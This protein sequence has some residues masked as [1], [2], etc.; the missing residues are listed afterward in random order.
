MK[1][2]LLL[3]VLLLLPP[4][5]AAGR[6]RPQQVARGVAAL[7]PPPRL[8]PVMGWNAWNTFSTNGK[9]MR[10]GRKV[11]IQALE[12]S[13]RRLACAVKRRITDGIC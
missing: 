9:P 4:T 11:A 12:P 6:P 5:P 10:G 8:T 2:L 7:P 1:L 13:R 3:M